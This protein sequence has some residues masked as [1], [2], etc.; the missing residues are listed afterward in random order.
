MTA[1]LDESAVQYV[2]SKLLSGE[3]RVGDAAESVGEV[4]G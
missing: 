4:V 1:F 3:I 2:L